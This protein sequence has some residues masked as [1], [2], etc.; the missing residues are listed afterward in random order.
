VRA[1][2]GPCADCRQ[3]CRGDCRERDYQDCH[4]DCDFII[5]WRH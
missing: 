4:H 2:S 1:E 5:R 3:D